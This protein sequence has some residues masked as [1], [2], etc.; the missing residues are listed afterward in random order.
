M[1][2]LVLESSYD[3]IKKMFYMI[4]PIAAFFIPSFYVW[5]LDF[6]P[7][8]LMFLIPIVGLGI[9]SNQIHQ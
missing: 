3:S 4:I 7:W 5:F 1:T 2:I 8:L 9:K 6:E